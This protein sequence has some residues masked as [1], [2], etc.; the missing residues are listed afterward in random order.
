MGRRGGSFG[1][2]MLLVVLVVVLMLTAR[3]WKAIAPASGAIMPTSATEAVRVAEPDT[4]GDAQYSDLPNVGEM[5]QTTSEHAD[6]VQEALDSI[7]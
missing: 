6:Q 5:Q 7:D 1:L 3:A 2:V 4:A